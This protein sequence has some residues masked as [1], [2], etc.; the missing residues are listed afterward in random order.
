MTQALANDLAPFDICVSSIVPGFIA[1]EDNE[2]NANI[3]EDK[4]RSEA[5]HSRGL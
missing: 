1:T 5:I 4:E 2:M 3:M